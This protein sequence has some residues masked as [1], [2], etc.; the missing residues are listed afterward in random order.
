M[1]SKKIGGVRED[2]SDRWD[3]TIDQNVQPCGNE[4]EVI[5]DFL[6]EEIHYS[7]WYFEFKKEAQLKIEALEKRLFK[8]KDEAIEIHKEINNINDELSN[9]LTISLK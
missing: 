2:F 7:L 9:R 8:I 4:C 5:H 3:G 1:E 6:G